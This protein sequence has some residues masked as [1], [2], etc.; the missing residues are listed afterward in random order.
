VVLARA[1]GCERGEN[2]YHGKRQDLHHASDPHFP[3]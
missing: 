1:S 2:G 3:L